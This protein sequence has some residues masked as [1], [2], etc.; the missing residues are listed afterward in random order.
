MTITTIFLTSRLQTIFFG[1]G[2]S[3]WSWYTVNRQCHIITLK[4]LSG[5]TLPYFKGY[6]S[7]LY[8]QC[9]FTL[10]TMKCNTLLFPHSVILYCY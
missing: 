9:Y 4:C 7:A 3:F 10:L 8:S 1:L 6:S 2:A 5:Q